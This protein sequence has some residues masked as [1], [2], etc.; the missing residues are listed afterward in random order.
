MAEGTTRLFAAPLNAAAMLQSNDA[1]GSA[2]DSTDFADCD[3]HHIATLHCVL[4]GLDPTARAPSRNP[5]WN[6][7]VTQWISLTNGDI[8]LDATELFVNGSFRPAATAGQELAES[9]DPVEGFLIFRLPS[10][11]VK[12]VVALDG[13]TLTDLAARWSVAWGSRTYANG[14][15]YPP[16][17]AGAARTALERIATMGRAAAADGEVLL[18]MCT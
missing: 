9:G 12:A 18:R 10:A 8:Y 13:P 15:K 17:S 5:V 6:E 4:D 3:P 11:V 16:F 14:S 1:R 7:F 2:F